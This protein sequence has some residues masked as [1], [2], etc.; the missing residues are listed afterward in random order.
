MDA[1]ITSYVTKE[2]KPSAR[3]PSETHWGDRRLKM[4]SQ[5]SHSDAITKRIIISVAK[6][7]D[8]EGWNQPAHVS[9]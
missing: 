3:L 7:C 5:A 9:A 1:D 2:F 4:W 8:K 6:Y